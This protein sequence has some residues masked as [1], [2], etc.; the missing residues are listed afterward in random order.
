[1]AVAGI[2]DY[3]IYVDL[4]DGSEIGVHKFTVLRD[5]PLWDQDV[6]WDVKR[7]APGSPS[8]QSIGMAG[9]TK[10]ISVSAADSARVT[11]Q[12]N[13]ASAILNIWNASAESFQIIFVTFHRGAV[14]GPAGLV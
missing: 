4:K 5:G 1:M 6:Q 14:N 7:L 3:S 12:A 13:F 8:G 9:Q 10:A 11:A 2:P